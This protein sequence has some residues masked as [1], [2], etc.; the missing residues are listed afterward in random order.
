MQKVEIYSSSICGYCF[1]VKRLLAG[2][3]KSF[4]E[5]NIQMDPDRRAEM[6]QRA[7]GLRTVPQI[8]NGAK[9]IGGCD[10]LFALER[11]GKLDALL[12]G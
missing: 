12:N 10:E 1:A 7:G 8:F 4:E 11:S 2:K 6:I 3:R 9:H 5:F